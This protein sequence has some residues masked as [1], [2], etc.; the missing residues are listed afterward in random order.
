MGLTDPVCDPCM[1]CINGRRLG[2]AVAAV[3]CNMWPA[4]LCTT[5]HY[6]SA[7][8]FVCLQQQLRDSNQP[9][10]EAVKQPSTV[11][12]HSLHKVAA[13]STP[14]HPRHVRALPSPL[15]DRA[16]SCR[17]L[18][19]IVLSCPVL[20]YVI[21]LSPA[22]SRSALVCTTPRTSSTVVCSTSMS[23]HCSR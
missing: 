23:E 11:H 12:E 18:P 6:Y 7:A 22:V 15:S 20:P 10:M 16:L 9:P 3:G 13:C 1:Q 5:E 8:G 4:I 2:M 19:C 21:F 17:V 14:Q